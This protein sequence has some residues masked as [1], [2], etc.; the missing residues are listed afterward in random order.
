MIVLIDS[1]VLGLLANPNKIGEAKKCEEW[2]YT[3]MAKG[4]YITTS[5]ICDYEV[6][7]NLILESLR[8]P[9]INSI[10]S[11]DELK[12]II[13]I[14]SLKDEVMY[15]A[16]ELWAQTRSQGNPTTNPKN[17]DADIILSAQ[18]RVL[19]DEYPGRYIVIAT[20]NIKHLN[21]FAEATLWQN[22]KF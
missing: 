19:L 13:S 12:G 5:I 11:L 7:R 21:L 17:I 15:L 2:L 8:R 16:A 3:L 10:A 20:T 6:R 22:I 9:K 14:L 1:G 4:V 18:Y